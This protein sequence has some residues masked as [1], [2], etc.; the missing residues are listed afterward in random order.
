MS[1]IK[2]NFTGVNADNVFEP[3][4]VGEAIPF[5]VFNIKEGQ[6]KTG[7]DKLTVEFQQVGTKRKTWEDYSLLPQALFKLKRLLIDLGV[8]KDDLEGDFDFDPKDVLGKEVLITFGPERAIPN[9]DKMGQ[10]KRITAA[11]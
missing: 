8:D 6:S 1:P 11:E 7:N 9:S 2:V 5:T 10:D 3:W 4:P